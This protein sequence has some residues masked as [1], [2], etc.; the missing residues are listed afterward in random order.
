LVLLNGE[1]IANNASN[2]ASVDL[3]M[4]PLVVIDRIEVLRDGASSLYGTDAIG[5]VINFITRRDYAGATVSLGYDQP[6]AAGGK[7]SSASIGFGRGDLSKDGYNL[8]GFIGMNNGQAISGTQRNFNKRIIESG[9]SNST[10]PANYTQDF[11]VFYNPA[12]PACSGT[13]LVPISGG[14]QCKIITPSFVD[15]APKTQTQSG[16]LKGSLRVNSELDLG[17]E[18]FAARNTVTAQIAPVP[19][20]GY[21]INPSLPAGITF[22]AVKMRATDNLSMRSS[23]LVNCLVTRKLRTASVNTERILQVLNETLTER[24]L[25]YGATLVIKA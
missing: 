21:L 14:T 1:R 6:Q 9:L 17:L 8:F 13:A 23:R 19:Y 18:L 16:M 3:N 2:G 7:N 15:H 11:S 5:G 4:I 24:P 12:A 22:L 25:L 10:A 20:G